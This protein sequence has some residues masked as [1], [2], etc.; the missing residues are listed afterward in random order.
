MGNKLVPDYEV[1]LLMKTEEVLDSNGNLKDSVVSQFKIKPGGTKMSIQ[2]IDTHDQIIYK[3]GWNLRIRK[4]EGDKKFGLTYKKRF[5]IDVSNSNDHSANIDTEVTRAHGEGFH[6]ASHFEAQVEVGY[7]KQTLSISHSQKVSGKDYDGM[8]LPHAEDSRKMLGVKAPPHFNSWSASTQ[9]SGSDGPLADAI[10][11]GPVSATRYTGQWEK[12]KL[13]IEVWPIR[14]SKNDQTLKPT[15][16]ASFKTDD[17]T[18][19]TDGLRRLGELLGEKGW[20]RAEDSLKTGLIMNAY[21]S[22]YGNV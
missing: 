17:V 11:Y 18:E 14:V 16:E 5:P 12:F 13:Y 1:K 20:L 2:F 4:S 15:V 19:A 10:V 8:D 22:V 21:G 7:T 9:G 3:N 6:D